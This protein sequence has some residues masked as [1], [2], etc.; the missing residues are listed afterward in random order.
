MFRRRKMLG[1]AVTDRSITAVEVVATNGGGRAGPAGEFV[2]PEGTGLAQPG[3]LGKA[4]RQ[5]LKRNGFSASRCVIGMAAHWLTG[6]HKTLPPGAAGSVGQ[7]LSLMIEREFAS[8]RKELVFD[9]ALGAEDDAE[10]SAFLVAAPRRVVDELV[11]LASAAGLAVAG[12]TATTLALAGSTDGSTAQDRLVLHL[13]A[14][15]AELALYSNG[16]VGLMRPLSVPAAAA[17]PAGGASTEGWLSDLTDQLRRVVALLPP[18]SRPGGGSGRELLVWDEAGLGRAGCKD[19]SDRLALPVRLCERPGELE[20]RGGERPAPGGQFSSAAVMALAALRGSPPPVDLL[21]S[22]LTP[23]RTFAVRRKAAWAAAVVA[24]IAVACA[25]ELWGWHS[26][27]VEAAAAQEK[28]TAMEGKLAEAKDVIAKV[29]FARPWYDR[30]RSY[31]DC[32][33]E[34]TLAF[35]EEGVIWAK[36]LAIQED[37]RVALYGRAVSGTAVVDVYDRLKASPKLSDVK[38]LYIRQA[39]R[40]TRDVLFAMSFTF[41]RRD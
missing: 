10:R 4:L 31:L 29:T 6:R 15:G 5:F 26:D 7:I 39:G 28:L 3:Q 24:A 36:S 18:A 35:P 20:L 8:D 27:S 12:I 37:M 33:R 22:R 11:A 19:L 34:L 41:T 17:P 38:V 32:V 2:F 9:Y 1:L 21:H 40:D 30:R 16:A 25:V 23:R 14:G 13:F